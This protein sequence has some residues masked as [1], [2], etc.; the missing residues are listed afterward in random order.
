MRLTLKTVA[1][2]ALKIDARSALKFNSFIFVLA[3]TISTA[4]VTA[5]SAA[6]ELVSVQFHV[7]ISLVAAGRCLGRG[8]FCEVLSNP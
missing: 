6:A 8:R 7:I 3:A 2:L 4:P 5:F 1:S